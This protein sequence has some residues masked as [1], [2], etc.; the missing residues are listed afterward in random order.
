MANR[1]AKSGS[2][3]GSAMRPIHAPWASWRYWN[4]RQR[5]LASGQFGSQ[6]AEWSTSSIAPPCL[7]KAPTLQAIIQAWCCPTRTSFKV[8]MFPYKAW[9]F[10]LVIHPCPRASNL[11]NEF[12]ALK[13]V[14]GYL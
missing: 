14:N 5:G 10:L 8:H 1:R 6:H 12:K 3:N 11:V 4:P 9:K 7:V 2:P 13:F